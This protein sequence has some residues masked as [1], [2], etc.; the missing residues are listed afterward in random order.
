MAELDTW[1]ELHSC[2]REDEQPAVTTP[3]H[4]IQTSR[5]QEI[6]HLEEKKY[7]IILEYLFS[8]NSKAPERAL[9]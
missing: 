3:A 8:R 6:K 7:I 4:W 2:P 5:Y 1:T 9:W